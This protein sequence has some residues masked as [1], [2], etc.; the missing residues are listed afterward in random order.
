MSFIS[1]YLEY[2]ANNEA[3]RMFHVWA[4][5]AALGAAIGRRA[6]LPFGVSALY[7]NPYVMLVGDAGNGKSRAMYNCMQVL[8]R[9]KP[10][11]AFTGSKE[12]PAGLWRFMTGDP[13]AKPV[14]KSP[15]MEL[16]KDARCPDGVKMETH[17]MFIRANEF[18][19]FIGLDPQGW[20]S[21]LNNIS[22][23][24]MYHYR[25]KNGGEDKIAGPYICMLAGLTTEISHSL[26]KQN[27]IATGLARRTWFQFGQRR[28]HDPHAILTQTE[29]EILAR[30]RC[31]EHL[32]KI[33]H[34]GGPFTWSEET[35]KWWTNWYN[36]HTITV[37]K[38]APQVRSWFASKP[39]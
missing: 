22:D 9:V 1:D 30:D 21:A 18:I 28:F 34:I 4:G 20:V 39:D 13:D 32:D 24:D 17:P 15:V 19:D 36:E 29:A 5:Y 12:T 14:R 31:V 38:K 10:P 23:E 8:K 25:T 33:R 16:V 7:C 11:I 3:P 26:Q 35:Q 2:A 6:W 37:P 27:I